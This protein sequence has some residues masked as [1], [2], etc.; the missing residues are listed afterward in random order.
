MK[1][2]MAILLLAGLCG[3][4]GALE[5]AVQI[6]AGTA[7]DLAKAMLPAAPAAASFY[8]RGSGVEYELGSITVEG[9]VEN[10]GPVALAG[11]PPR[12]AAVRQLTYVNGKPFFS[13]AYMFYGYALHDILNQKRLKKARAD[14]KPETDLFVVV[15]NAKGEK[16]VLSWGEIFYSAEPF[17]ALIASGMRSVNPGKKNLV[18]P[19]YGL[20]QLVCAKDLYDSRFVANPVKITVKSAPGEF[21]GEKHQAVYAPGFKVVYGDKSYTVAGAAKAGVRDYVT[22]GYGHGTGFKEIKNVSGLLLKD[23]LAGTGIAPQDSA[24]KLAVVSAGDGYRAAFSLAEL[25][26]RGDN[27]DPVLADRGKEADGRYALFA[28]ADFFVDRNVRSVS[29]IEILKI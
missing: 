23:L 3:A 5:P 19:L 26:N 2:N 15:E 17:S 8:E 1:T 14:F 9:E 29:K 4:A 13:G 21:P 25:L 7:G 6:P 16:A 18:W 27:E 22:A 11:L 28:P 24:D 12:Q 20:P 10:P